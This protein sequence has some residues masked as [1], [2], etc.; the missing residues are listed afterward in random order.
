ME[1]K[2]DIVLLEVV[3]FLFSGLIT[4]SQYEFHSLT[5][6]VAVSKLIKAMDTEESN[7]IEPY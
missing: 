3:Y 2:T 4:M 5:H 6:S 1:E 7:V